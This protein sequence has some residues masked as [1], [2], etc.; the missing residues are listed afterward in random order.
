MNQAAD[1]QDWDQLSDSE[2]NE[3]LD[4]RIAQFN[5]ERGAIKT[6]PPPHA[7]M[8]NEYERGINNKLVTEDLI[9]HYADA[10]GDPNPLWRDPSYAQGTRWGGIIAPPTFES[11]I[12]FGSSFGGRLRV[13]GVARLAAGNRHDYVKPFRP[14]DS[15]SVYDKYLGFEEKDVPG[16]PYRMFI[17]S[18]PRYFVNQRDETIAVATGRNIYMAT[19]PGKRVE[20]K[21]DSSLYTDKQRHFFSDDELDVIHQDFDAQLAGVNRRGAKTRYWE[22]VVEGEDI[23]PVHKGIYDVCDAC[24]RTVVSCYTYAFAIKWAAMRH[25]LDHHPRDPET[26]EHR[27]RRDWHYDDHAARLFGVPYANAGG[28]HNEMMLVHLV[29]DWMG[30]DGFVRSMDSQDRRMNFLGDATVVK[31]QV[32]RKYA[33]D[34]DHLVDLD[35]RAENQDGVVHTKATVTVKLISKAEA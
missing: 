14:M 35:V 25:H 13:P 3:R 28:I 19:P 30:D 9:R 27:F 21:K 12:S 26:N 29:T 5:D 16:K 34:G 15:F 2:W 32:A 10:I 11:A 31:G 33:D 6:P 8:D 17:E 22:D 1:E 24:A 7:I 20:R 4:A 18:V 23:T